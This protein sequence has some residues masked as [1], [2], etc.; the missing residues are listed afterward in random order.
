MTVETVL[1]VECSNVLPT[2]YFP[3]VH[4]YTTFTW[5][6]HVEST[7]WGRGGGF[8]R[9]ELAEER[10]EL[11]VKSKSLANPFLFVGSGTN[12]ISIQTIRTYLD[13]SPFFLSF[14]S[15]STFSVWKEVY[16][17]HCSLPSLPFASKRHAM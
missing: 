16:P 2:W 17:P 12:L 1:I 4:R 9:D 8:V 13:P 15:S 10:V 7:H 11:L 6:A 5:S 14:S 3:T